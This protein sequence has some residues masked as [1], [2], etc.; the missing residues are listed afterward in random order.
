MGQ[1]TREQRVVIVEQYY[2]NKSPTKV[3][4]AFANEYILNINNKTVSDKTLFAKTY[5][6]RIESFF[7]E[8]SINL[9]TKP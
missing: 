4:R 8:Q 2:S 5:V 9:L 6:L 7:F 3:K 1:L